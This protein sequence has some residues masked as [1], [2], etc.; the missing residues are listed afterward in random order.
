[1]T[2]EF[3]KYTEIT[4]LYKKYCTQ[5][6]EGDGYI[7]FFIC[8]DVKDIWLVRVIEGMNSEY[9]N[10]AGKYLLER[11]KIEKTSRDQKLSLKNV[12]EIIKNDEFC[13]WDVLEFDSIEEIIDTISDGFGINNL[14]E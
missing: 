1:M 8:L 14:A 6:S 3:A 10:E 2:F 7:R 11:D 13:N 5:L 12:I 9:E 4:E